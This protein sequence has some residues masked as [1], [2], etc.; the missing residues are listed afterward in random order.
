MNAL[1]ICAKEGKANDIINDWISSHED[2]EV[3]WG[4]FEVMNAARTALSA[5]LT[6]EAGAD[7]LH[8][9]ACRII[10]TGT[11]GPEEEDETEV[12]A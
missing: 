4:M 9:L 7:V 5:C 12:E 11:L 2:D 10:A 3:R 6:A 8:A 1:E